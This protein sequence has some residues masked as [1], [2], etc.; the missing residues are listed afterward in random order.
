MNLQQLQQHNQELSILNEIAQHLNK[1][2]E[3]QKALD[4][5]LQQV[6]DLFHLKT[7]WIWLFQPE[8]RTTW[9]AASRN[10]PP[11]L[12]KEPER[13]TGWC[14]CIEKY[15]TG[16]MENASNISEITCT[17]LKDLTEGT[18]EL[19][20][21]ASVPLFSQNKKIGILNVVSKNSQELSD[22][23]L[24]LLY[25]IGDMLSI[26]I[27]RARWFENS[28]QIGIVQE[29]NRL[30]REIH[31]TLAQGLSAISLKLQTLEI[32]LENQTSEKILN[33]LDQTIALTQH[34][35]EEA[36]RSVLD[37]RATPLQDKNLVEALDVLLQKT[38][39]ESQLKTDLKVI[40]NY[41]KLPL[42]IEMG[43]Y[44]IAQEAIQNVI[45]HAQAT[46]ISLQFQRTDKTIEL[47]I[48]DNG[49]GFEEH[50]INEN[51]FGLI[52]LKERAKLLKASLSVSSKK[53]KGTVI[54]VILP[55]VSS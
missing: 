22:N 40:G 51:S 49:R 25:T 52:G 16:N 23:Q 20:Y 17:R 10:L 35:L 12:Q 11:I 55:F 45:K 8:T 44:R 28:K 31:D 5:T 13:L 53:S 1:E 36:R 21:H 32:L 14:Y 42:R 27:E 15:L 9:V 3:L 48:K 39:R 54:K 34:N 38:K 33:I 43:L 24:K 4:A 2:V 7:A 37:L 46:K 18:N 26:A 29:R 19:R 50:S 6:V 30:A 41:Q 47:L